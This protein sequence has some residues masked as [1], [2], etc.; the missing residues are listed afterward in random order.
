MLAAANTTPSGND[1]LRLKYSRQ[2]NWLFAIFPDKK[3]SQQLVVLARKRAPCFETLAKK[4][5]GVKDL[6]EFRAPANA[7]KTGFQEKAGE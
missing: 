7:E 6:I 3:P 4:F 5:L 1:S 2:D